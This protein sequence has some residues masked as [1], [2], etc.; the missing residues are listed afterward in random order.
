VDDDQL[1][2]EHKYYMALL[3][4][5]YVRKNKGD[6][7]DFIHLPG[8]ELNLLDLDKIIE[9]CRSSKNIETALILAQKTQDLDQQLNILINDMKDYDRALT[10]ISKNMGLDSKVTYLKRFGLNLIEKASDMTYLV[11]KDVTIKLIQRVQEKPSE[12]MKIKMDIK[13]L[14]E[15]LV[16]NKDLSEDFLRFQLSVDPNCGSEVYHA[17]IELYAKAYVTTREDESK[18]IAALGKAKSTENPLLKTQFNTLLNFLEQNRD[19]YDQRHAL[20][21]C[22]MYQIDEG[23]ELLYEMLGLKNELMA[24][25]IQ[26]KRYKDIIKYCKSYGDIDPNLWIQT[27]NYFVNELNANPI[28]TLI[29]DFIKEALD[30]MKSIPSISPLLVLEVIYNCKSLKFSALKDYM[31]NM[32]EKLQDKINKNR[33]IVNGLGNDIEDLKQ[34]I[35]G[36][37]TTAQKFQ[38]KECHECG[39]YIDPPLVQFICSHIY[40]DYCIASSDSL[41]KDCPKCATMN[42]QLIERKEQLE[43]QA[44]N[45][46]AFFGELKASPLKFSV[47]S[48]YLGRRLFFEPPQSTSKDN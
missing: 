16:N 37:R 36:L 3:L 15:I 39:K 17:L 46:E 45:Q 26:K 44:K 1:M 8:L 25:Y 13:L 35:K 9:T 20:M 22:E 41:Q 28:N 18:H 11:I 27:L 29:Q 19:K 33:K 48:K 4:N 42:T 38:P 7:M 2:D 10:L 32:V 40:H 30:N 14:Q 24:H 34:N 47:I 12:M 6:M 43:I 23:I 5:C 21:I 31:A